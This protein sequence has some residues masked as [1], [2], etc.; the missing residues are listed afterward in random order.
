MILDSISAAQ[1]ETE[2]TEH[3]RI[4]RDWLSLWRSRA[5]CVSSDV[6]YFLN[7]H[8]LFSSLFKST[9]VLKVIPDAKLDGHELHVGDVGRDGDIPSAFSI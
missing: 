9:S 4:W 7:F 2:A 1:E 6:S 8:S 3:E 5:R